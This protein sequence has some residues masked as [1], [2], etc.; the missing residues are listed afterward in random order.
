ME[1]NSIRKKSLACAASL[2]FSINEFL[3]LLGEKIYEKSAEQIANRLLCLHVVAACSYGFNREEACSWIAQE[4][5]QNFLTEGEKIFLAK[6]VGEKEKY[7]FQIEGM[8]ALSWS[9]GLVP[10][11]DFSKGCE[12]SFALLLPNL[13]ISESSVVLRS[14]LVLRSF[15][16][17]FEQCDL[18]YCLHWAIR[19]AQICSNAI[20]GKVQP[21]VIIERRR[22]LEWL[23]GNEDW[24]NVIL[25]T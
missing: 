2:G 23:I 17:I 4:N 18:A 10:R 6:G 3:P 15:D 12:S 21:Y 11:L 19:Q 9:L 20:P 7:H 13:K 25:D 8:W 1:N 22:A 14:K 16:S 24:D 5:L